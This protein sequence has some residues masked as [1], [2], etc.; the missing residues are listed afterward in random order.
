MNAATL[1][2]R[3]DASDKLIEINRLRVEEMVPEKQF[4]LAIT[5]MKS[6]LDEVKADVKEIRRATAPRR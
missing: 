6:E 1:R 5:D 3:M 4:T 2:A